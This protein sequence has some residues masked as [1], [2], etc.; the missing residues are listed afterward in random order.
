[1]K[2][3]L[4]K[5]LLERGLAETRSKA[6]GLIMSGSVVVDGRPV[7]KAGTE[8]PDG[9]QIEVKHA[10]PYVSRGGL[11]LAAALD[12]FAIDLTGK[13]V[14]DVGAS[15]G[16]FTDVMLQRGVIRVYALDVG[17]GQLHYR[18]RGD[19]RVINIEGVNARTIEPGLI[20]EQCDF[21]T[22][23]VSFI[24]LRLVIPP[25]LAVLKPEAALVALVKP[26]FEAGRTLVKKG[27]VRDENVIAEVL[28]SMEAFVHDTGLKVGGVVPSPIK[29]AKGNQEYLM[30]LLR[31]GPV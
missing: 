11:K 22:F 21:A 4:D 29:G 20:P 25:I 30:H 12:A 5:L 23:D 6:L 1:M 26:Q 13:V 10:L 27:I 3:R 14:V 15:T 16:G 7:T 9:A 19:P 31:G 24:S 28:T 2:T 8:I 18:L 17:H